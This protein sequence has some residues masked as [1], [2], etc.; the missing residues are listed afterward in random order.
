MVGKAAW[1]FFTRPGH[2]AHLSDSFSQCRFSYVRGSKL[3]DLGRFQKGLKVE[4]SWK[5]EG[6]DPFVDPFVGPIT[7]EFFFT[8]GGR[9][10]TISP[11]QVEYMVGFESSSHAN[12]T[13][14]ATSK[15]FASTR[16]ATGPCGTKRV[17]LDEGDPGH[18][19]HG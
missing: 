9:W 11:E 17:N 12:L 16:K 15:A 19:G 2:G 8:F 6:F 7:F 1:V 4:R 10:C 18:D 5:L 3:G 13:S 14:T